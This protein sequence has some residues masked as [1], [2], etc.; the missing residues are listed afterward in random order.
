MSIEIDYDTEL[1]LSSEGLRKLPD[2]SGY[3]NLQKIDC[4][5]NKL[6]SLDNLPSTLTELSC[7]KN[8][9]TFLDNLPSP[10]TILKCFVN[11]LQYNFEPTLKNIRAY[12]ANKN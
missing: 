10:L 8:Q 12:N 4:R 2:L 7:Y 3:I 5:N 9:L 6:T 1:D 11:P